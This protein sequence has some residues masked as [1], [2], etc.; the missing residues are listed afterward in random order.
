MEK[1]TESIEIVDREGNG[2]NA[3]YWRTR[4]E[5]NLS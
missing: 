2:E 5:N 4:K 1:E 3:I